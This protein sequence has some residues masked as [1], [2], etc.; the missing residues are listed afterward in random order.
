MIQVKFS[1]PF[2]IVVE[3]D[4]QGETPTS[5]NL[6]FNNGTVQT[7]TVGTDKKGYFPFADGVPA[8]TYPVDTWLVNEGGS[9]PHVQE[10]I[11]STKQQPHSNPVITVEV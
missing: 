3:W 10:V 5:I 9:G 1:K 2:T 7:T 6:V 4:G 8:G 11:Q